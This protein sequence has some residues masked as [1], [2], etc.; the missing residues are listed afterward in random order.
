MSAFFIGRPFQIAEGPEKL[1]IINL[2]MYLEIP[3]TS[4]GTSFVLLTLMD[5]GFSV[6]PDKFFK[7][8]SS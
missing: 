7:D 6:I 1:D 3:R 2:S 8:G 4:N 5:A